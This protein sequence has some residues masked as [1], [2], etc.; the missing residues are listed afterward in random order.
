M[1]IFRSRREIAGRPRKLSPAEQLQ[2]DEARVAEEANFNRIEFIEAQMRAWNGKLRILEEAGFA[3]D[4]PS[5]NG[6]TIQGLQK[7]ILG[8]AG[9]LRGLGVIR[10]SEP[11]E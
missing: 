1:A 4:E 3:P 8:N 11:T 7:S 2:E 5:K 6:E 10:G 9:T